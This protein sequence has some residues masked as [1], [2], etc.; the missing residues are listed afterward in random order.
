VLDHGV[1][2]GQRDQCKGDVARQLHGKPRLAAQAEG[3]RVE[4]EEGKDPRPR[5]PDEPLHLSACH[6]AAAL[7]IR[8]EQD[9]ERAGEQRREVEGPPA[10]D[11]RRDQ[12][13]QLPAPGRDEQHLARHCGAHQEQRG[14]VGRGDQPAPGGGQSALRKRQ[15]EVQKDHGKQEDRQVVHPEDR[16]VRQVQLPGVGHRV[17]QEEQ[18]ADRIE[19]DG[20]PIGRPAQHDDGAHDEAEEAHQGEV[21]EEGHI[22]LGQRADRHLEG[23]T[24]AKPE[25]RVPDPLPRLPVGQASLD[26]LGRDDRLAIEA[27]QDVPGLH[28]RQRRRAPGRHAAGDGA[29]SAHL[30]EHPVVH[31][32][33]GGLQEDVV[34][35]EASEDEGDA[36][37]GGVLGVKTFQHW[38]RVTLRPRRASTRIPA[39]TDGLRCCGVISRRPATVPIMQS[40]CRLAR[41]KRARNSLTDSRFQPDPAPRIQRAGSRAQT[42]GSTA[43]PQKR[44]APRHR[45]HADPRI[46]TRRVV[47]ALRS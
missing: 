24:L 32:G 12:P 35:P 27:Q 6:Q 36:Q 31:Q 15:A 23:A 4:D 33:P 40:P 22:A 8:V 39:R 13:E 44:P 2:E 37:D 29:L 25:Q 11:G 19:V 7:P 3:D 5:A 16:P 46:V 30:P 45:C 43:R 14:Q 34:H 9:P 1:G 42:F 21:V 38:S 28:S 20:S 41:R 17:H 47:R 18:Q 10:V 26:L